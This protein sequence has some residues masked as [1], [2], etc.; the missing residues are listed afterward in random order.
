MQFGLTDTAT[1][2]RSRLYEDDDDDD[3]PELSSSGSDRGD[4]LLG[5]PEQRA[6][7]KGSSSLPRASADAAGADSDDELP[8]DRTRCNP[9]NGEAGGGRDKIRID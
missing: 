5:S 8:D 6:A 1:K 4:I 3:E 2:Q 7:L 9:A